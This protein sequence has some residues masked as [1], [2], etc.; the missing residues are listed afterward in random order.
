MSP[1]D[2]TAMNRW[3]DHRDADAFRTLVQRHAGKVYAT[4]KRIIG[5]ATAAEDITQECFETLAGIKA[6]TQIQAL[7]PWLHG[8]ATKRCLVHIRGEGR[9][10]VREARYVAEQ[11]TKTEIEWND[12]YESIDEAIAALPDK[13][14]YPLVAH[15][16]YGESHAA[17]ARATGVP[18]R[19]VSSRIQR[20]VDSVGAHL[21]S[22][23]IAVPMVTLA[24]MCQANL[25]TAA[26][27][28]YTLETTL[29]KISLAGSGSTTVTTGSSGPMSALFSM[30]GAA[31]LIATLTIV[32]TT[33]TYVSL[34]PTP[35]T[36]EIRTQHTSNAT[37]PRAQPDS[38][39]VVP[40]TTSALPAA[41]MQV[42][43]PNP[44]TPPAAIIEGRVTFQGEA[45]VGV[46]VGGTPYMAAKPVFNVTTNSDGYYRTDGLH[47]QALTVTT[48]LY[49]VDGRP[50]TLA[51]MSNLGELKSPLKHDPAYT[52]EKRI[53]LDAGKKLRIDFELPGLSEPSFDASAV[54]WLT[55]YA[56]IDGQVPRHTQISVRAADNR[57][58]AKAD[59]G[60]DGSYTA[61]PIPPGEYLVWLN[62]LRPPVEW[63]TRTSVFAGEGT[64]LEINVD[65]R[66]RGSIR[67]DIYGLRDGE[68]AN[69]VVFQGEVYVPG[70]Y[71]TNWLA[72]VD[73]P[74]AAGTR[75]QRERNEYVINNLAPGPYTVVVALTSSLAPGVP[76]YGFLD[77]RV[78]H[79]AEEGEEAIADFEFVSEDSPV[80]EGVLTGLH[81]EDYAWVSVYQGEFPMPVP[82]RENVT[83]REFLA[84]Q[85]EA[86]L[87]RDI[88]IWNLKPG[89]YTIWAS[90]TPEKTV[91]YTRANGFAV[92]FPG[93][94]VGYQKTDWT[95]VTIPKDS[96]KPV[97]I[98][99]APVVQ[100]HQSTIHGR[101]LN[102]KPGW[103]EVLA[104][105]V[106]SAQE[107]PSKAN[108][109]YWEKVH[110]SAMASGRALDGDTVVLTG[111][112]QGT[113]K[114]FAFQFPVRLSQEVRKAAGFNMEDIYAKTM[115]ASAEV[116]IRTADEK[117][118]LD[119][120]F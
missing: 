112:K 109:A 77:H 108:E 15:Y 49:L 39:D 42:R 83:P 30:K 103:R 45:A 40:S 54:G 57:E 27:L 24:A 14:C 10:R 118:Q 101:L 53:T 25:A 85:F 28:S 22:R 8:M 16:L 9:R 98:E 113:Y 119:L 32:A 74:V 2:K 3:I 87:R 81:A 38:I 48:G 76:H 102:L 91:K 52:S 100:T 55:G 75:F 36:P 33:T 72:D 115:I 78:V 114:V 46:F 69:T 23:G 110:L 64:V 63:W 43:A 13:L 20:G 68:T 41:A 51:E 107:L 34:R 70:A 4:C 93:L 89:T 104:Y 31:L 92:T 106:P 5:D 6:E 67:G 56:S 116:T 12:V 60:D 111:L 1:I 18:R 97:R 65:Q 19:T 26:P 94:D 37:P 66:H 29:G 47:P 7:G 82:Y 58:I 21:K 95:M 17:I 61:G 11:D 84:T 71:S 96:E 59:V 44:T 50:V 62:G 86:G 99:L 88:E 90:A 35:D 117:A 120:A 105:A 80:I 79:I 73:A